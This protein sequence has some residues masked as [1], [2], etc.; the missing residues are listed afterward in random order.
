M[1]NIIK[2]KILNNIF[3]FLALLM[4]WNIFNDVSWT[5]L[6]DFLMLQLVSNGRQNVVNIAGNV[7]VL[8]VINTKV[9]VKKLYG[10]QKA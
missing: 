4:R 10:I 7:Y 9:C 5:L 2:I 8:M 1:L 3:T 6:P